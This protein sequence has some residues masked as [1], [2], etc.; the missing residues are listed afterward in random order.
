[1]E[2]A[3]S[4]SVMLGM[5]GVGFTKGGQNWPQICSTSLSFK[6]RG[7]CF[8]HTFKYAHLTLVSKTPKLAQLVKAPV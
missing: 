7:Y 6:D 4:Y 2:A 8:G 5:R 1:M 3:N